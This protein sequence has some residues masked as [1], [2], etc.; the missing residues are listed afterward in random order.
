MRWGQGILATRGDQPMKRQRLCE[1][2]D[3]LKPAIMKL[4]EG[5]DAETV[6]MWASLRCP[7]RDHCAKDRPCE[8]MNAENRQKISE[9]QDKLFVHGFVHTTEK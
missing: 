1:V 6:R 2:S 8:G 3:E 5:G 9:L 4:G 7:K